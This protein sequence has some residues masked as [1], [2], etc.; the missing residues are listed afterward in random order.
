MTGLLHTL[1]DTYEPLTGDE[2]VYLPA[3][4]GGTAPTLEEANAMD[5]QE[6]RDQIR[7][8]SAARKAER[9]KTEGA[10]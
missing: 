1:Q 5:D 4:L 9:A 8:A 7:A 3:R 6:R 10:Q 2:L